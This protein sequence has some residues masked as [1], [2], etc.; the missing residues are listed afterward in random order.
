MIDPKLKEKLEVLDGSRGRKAIRQAAVR[1]EDLSGLLLLPES[2]TAAAAAGSTPTKA[3]FDKL[4]AD[5]STLHLR[6]LAVIE[7][8]QARLL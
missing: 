2:L 7:A 4:V 8:L 5:V 1:I 3:E 6:M